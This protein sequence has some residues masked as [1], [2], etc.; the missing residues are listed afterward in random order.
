MGL[1][2]SVSG[3]DP[4]GIHSLGT[5]GVNNKTIIIM[6]NQETMAQVFEEF[7]MLN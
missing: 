1:V 6:T 5:R 2:R 4:D 3:S 7:K